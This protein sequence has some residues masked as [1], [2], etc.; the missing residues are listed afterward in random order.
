MPSDTSPTPSAAASANLD[1]AESNAAFQPS[2]DGTSSVPRRD[3]LASAVRAVSGVTMLSRLGGLARDVLLL[4]IFGAT[5]IGSAF[6]A[7]FT[8]PNLFRR[9]LGEGALSAAFLPEYTRAMKSEREAAGPLASATIRI[10]LLTSGLLTAVLEIGLLLALALLPLN[11]KRDLSIKLVMVMLPFMPLVCVAAILSGMLQAHGR[12]GPASSGPI[13][14][15]GF[16]IAVGVWSL[17]T[18]RLAGE[19]VAYVLGIA[20][21]LSGLTQCV[22]YARLLRPHVE[23]RSDVALVRGRLRA[24]FKRF[25]PVVVG[26]GSLQLSTLFDMVI[27][28][29]PIWVGPTLL[30]VAYPLDGA[31]NVL[32]NSAARLYQFPLGVFGIAVA[33]AIFPLLS[34]HAEEPGHFAAT[35]KRGIRLSLFIGLPASAGLV[36]VRH[37]IVGVLYSGGSRGLS[38][39]DQA[40]CAAIVAGYGVGIWAYSLNHVFTRALYAKGDTKT[41]MRVSIAMVLLSLALNLTLI[42]WLREAGMAWATSIAASVQTMVLAMIC[43]RRFGVPALGPPSPSPPPSPPFLREGSVANDQGVLHAIVRIV[44]ATGLMGAGVW[45]ALR[46]LPSV[47]ESAWRESLVRMIV[48]VACGGLVYISAARALRCHELG[49]LMGRRARVGASV[50]GAVH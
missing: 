49:W 28:M 6:A 15:N 40:R 31:S 36:L 24:M 16:I 30:G 11:P 21:V 3:P 4:R 26:T 46:F 12:F 34:R 48:G 14:L 29:W 20:T 50:D 18:G 33:T 9:L 1:V 23:W 38:M 8:I 45:L 7:G 17:A 44:V 27:A 22:W 35:L 25:V 13:I 5:A 42:W 43:R 41:P 47:G 2:R 37:E 10:L 39:A 19:G 32:L